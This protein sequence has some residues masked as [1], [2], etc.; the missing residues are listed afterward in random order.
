MS[1]LGK[2][3]VAGSMYAPSCIED[4][5]SDFLP[6][7]AKS[8]RPEEA[9]ATRRSSIKSTS[10]L[11]TRISDPMSKIGEAMHLVISGDVD[12]NGGRRCR[13]GQIA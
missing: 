2:T 10:L 11:Q 3:D 6:P 12:Y 8:G 13:I 9:G 5:F 7:W 4:R 1:G